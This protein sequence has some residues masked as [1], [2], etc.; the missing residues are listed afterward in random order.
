MTY[1][2]NIFLFFQKNEFGNIPL[3]LDLEKLILTFLITNF[4]WTLVI[5]RG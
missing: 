3:G 1:H 2:L 5:A 4:Q